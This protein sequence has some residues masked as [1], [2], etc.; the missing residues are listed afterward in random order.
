MTST[1]SK[2]DDIIDIR[3]VIARVE[4]LRQLHTPGPLDLGEDDNEQ[5]QD[6]LWVFCIRHELFAGTGKSCHVKACITAWD[7]VSN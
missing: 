1:I 6:D 3:D 4:H 2:Y 5:H 7:C